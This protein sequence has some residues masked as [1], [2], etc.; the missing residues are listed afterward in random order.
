MN[1]Y[2]FFDTRSLLHSVVFG[3]QVALRLFNGLWQLGQVT[4]RN[5]LY[6]LVVE[7]ILLRLNL[8]HWTFKK[9]NLVH[10]HQRTVVVVIVL[11][12]PELCIILAFVSNVIQVEILFILIFMLMLMSFAF[13]LLCNHL[14]NSLFGILSYK[15]NQC[16]EQVR[17]DVKDELRFLWVFH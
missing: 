5:D 16:F 7:C 11:L 10:Y 3:K 2:R 17:E 14:L 1:I 8:L 12:L 6:H 9:L 13:L 15:L 4:W